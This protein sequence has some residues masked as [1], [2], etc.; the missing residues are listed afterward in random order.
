MPRRRRS[1]NDDYDSDDSY[2]PEDSV[3]DVND[4]DV[5]DA[6]TDITDIDPCDDVNRF[7]D[8]DGHGDAENLPELL[9]DAVHP[10]EYHR[11]IAEEVN[12]GDFDTQDYSRGTDSSTRPR[13]TGAD[14]QSGEEGRKMKGI[15]TRNSLGTNWK[16]FRLAY[17]KA[18]RAKLDPK[19]N[20]QMHKVRSP[21][22]FWP[23]GSLSGR[24]G[25]AKSGS[26]A[27]TSTRRGRIAA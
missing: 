1:R 17:E 2:S 5:S 9:D 16:I 13:D 3:F 4:V 14:L 27:Q 12:V 24:P 15:K 26:G 25:P 22:P 7:D 21:Q 20:R 18:V 11:R 10:P 8:V 23:S 19:L 6:D